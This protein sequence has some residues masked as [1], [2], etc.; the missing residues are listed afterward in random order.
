MMIV[1]A[2]NSAATERA[3]YLLV[4]AY[5]ESLHP[6]HHDMGI[7]ESIVS[8]PIEGVDDLSDRLTALSNDSN[9]PLQAV[10]PVLEISAVLASA[11]QRLG[12]NGY[13]RIDKR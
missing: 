12:E 13:S 8:L 7:P 9:E 11:L 6:F 4:T 3:V 1:E 10:V 2:I 5:L